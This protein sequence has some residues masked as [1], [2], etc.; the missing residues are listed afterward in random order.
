MNKDIFNSDFF[1]WSDAGL[2]HNYE[3]MTDALVPQHILGEF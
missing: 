1:V 2:L 3:N